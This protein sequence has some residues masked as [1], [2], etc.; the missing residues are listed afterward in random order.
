MWCGNMLSEDLAIKGFNIGT[1]KSYGYGSG[2][3]AT[4]EN[5]R[6][7]SMGSAGWLGPRPWDARPPLKQHTV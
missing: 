2:K 6:V 7:N 5:L 4:P 3:S 1:K